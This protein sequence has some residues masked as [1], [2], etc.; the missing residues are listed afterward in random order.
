MSPSTANTPAVPLT[1][2]DRLRRWRLVLG[3]EA[4][5]ACGKLSGAFAEMDQALSA[6]YDA[7]PKKGLGGTDCKGG[8]GGS[9][10]SVARDGAMQ[11][12]GSESET[13]VPPAWRARC[14]VSVCGH[15]GC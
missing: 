6:L 2:E 8:R 3:G 14:R 9:A 1:D 10:P 15:R 5:S 13:R 4:E 7:D 11:A 12:S